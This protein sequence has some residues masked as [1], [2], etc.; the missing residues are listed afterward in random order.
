MHKYSNNEDV[1]NKKVLRFYFGYLR[2]LGYSDN[3]LK[4]DKHILKIEIESCKNNV[5][6]KIFIMTKT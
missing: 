4:R 6:G 1:R 2:L 3:S 5:L